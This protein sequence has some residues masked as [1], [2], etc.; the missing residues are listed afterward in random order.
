MRQI[1]ITIT[2]S[3]GVLLDS[4]DTTI[5]DGIK[6]LYIAEVLPDSD[7]IEGLGSLHIGA[8]ETV[9]S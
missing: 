7:I 6:E 8:G 3:E 4:L 2:D 9:W 1:K 5:R